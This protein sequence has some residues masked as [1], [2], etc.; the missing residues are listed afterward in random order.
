MCALTS[1][2]ADASESY[3]GSVSVDPTAIDTVGRL[4]DNARQGDPIALE[5]LL[6]IVYAELHAIA[7]RHMRR[8]SSWTTPG[9]ATPRSAAARS[10]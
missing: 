10:R 2:D 5:R 7:E 9:P 8:R 1:I 6:P 4:L 3:H